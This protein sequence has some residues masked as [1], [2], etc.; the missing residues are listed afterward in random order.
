MAGPSDPADDNL[1]ASIA[2]HQP[3][4]GGL[5][6]WVGRTLDLRSGLGAARLP[7]G[8][9]ANVIDL[10]GGQGLAISTDGVGTK[11]LVAQ[12]MRRYH[13]VG[14]DCVAMNVNDV[15]CVG[16]EP[17]ALVDYL[18]VEDPRP[19]LLEEIGKGLYEG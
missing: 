7:L 5:L 15:L 4:L 10:G 13:T 9:F 3:G 8:Q 18:A 6:R 17:L 1:I 16:A 11:L 2:R 14:I 12:M 19:R